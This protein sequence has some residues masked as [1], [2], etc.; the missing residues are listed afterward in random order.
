MKQPLLSGYA[1]A[2]GLRAIDF[3]GT[4]GFDVRRLFAV[5]NVT[6]NVTI[7]AAGVTG[8][9]I[10]SAVGSVVTFTTD[11]TGMANSDALLVLYEDGDSA[12]N[13]KLEQIRTVLT[14][15]ATAAKQDEAK[16]ALAAIGS[17]L[18]PLG[19]DAT[20]Q[21]ILTTLKAQR[22]ETI[23]TDDTGAR[24][25]RVDIGGAIVWTDVAGNAS[26]PP[27][28]GARPDSDSSTVVSRSTFKATAGGTGFAV[29][30]VLD[31]LVVTD[32][33]AGDLVSNFWINVTAGTK[34]AAP[35][36]ASITPMSPLPDG[37]S[38]AARQDT[39]NTAL[40]G[41]GAGLGAPADTAATSD[42]GAFSLIAL[43]KR[44]LANWT[45]LL[46]RIPVLGQT[47]K[48][49]SLPVTL[50]SDE[51]SLPVSLTTGSIEFADV[52]N[53]T[54]GASSS[55]NAVAHDAGAA[56]R[57]W[58][59]VNAMF[60][61]G[62]AVNYTIQASSSSDFSNAVIIASGTTTA[63]AATFFNQRILHRYHRAF[64]TNPS[65]SVAAANTFVQ[66]GYSAG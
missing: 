40:T 56:P 41:I 57:A 28:A 15:G 35:S 61:S 34:I 23:W 58:S 30:D 52:V 22:V 63:G 8:L 65:S 7:F 45:T 47:T 49:G 3:G 36:A 55:T 26:S 16:A 14:A 33:D 51:G 9:G 39:G 31:H 13:S 4:A 27:G 44:A 42:G 10:E 54:V 37:A 2:P 64:V 62:A 21:Q 19:T 50:A 43:A 66:M 59:F 24:F 48:A 12:S 53:Q 25:I 38:T 11:T 6:R 5:I 29:G 1:F 46:A 32:G 20:L 18:V 60:F 17:A